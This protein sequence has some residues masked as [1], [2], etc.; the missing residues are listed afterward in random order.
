MPLTFEEAAAEARQR[1]AATRVQGAVTQWLQDL[2]ARSD[3]VLVMSPSESPA[4][5]RAN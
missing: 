4:T 5:P 3:V 1:A 2:R